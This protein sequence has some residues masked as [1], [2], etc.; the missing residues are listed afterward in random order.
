VIE[1]SSA[2]GGLLHVYTLMYKGWAARLD[3][4]PVV[5]ETH[6]RLKTMLIAVPAGERRLTLT[7]EET[8]TRRLARWI[9]LVALVL[10]VFMFMAGRLGRPIR[11][12]A[13]AV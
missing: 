11:R 8:G 4:S 9:S 12:R 3:G 7:F 6:P 10:I 13:S 1:T 5:I 2:T